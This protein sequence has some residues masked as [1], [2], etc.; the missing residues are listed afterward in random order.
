MDKGLLKYEGIDRKT[1]FYIINLSPEDKPEFIDGVR[2]DTVYIDPNTSQIWNPY[3]EM[4]K[5]KLNNE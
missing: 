1:G 5:K 4:L 2:K 3:Q